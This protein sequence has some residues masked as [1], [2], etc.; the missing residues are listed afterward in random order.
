MTDGCSETANHDQALHSSNSVTDGDEMD[1]VAVT[2]VALIDV[3]VVTVGIDRSWKNRSARRKIHQEKSQECGG[4]Q[5]TLAQFDTEK[6]CAACHSQFDRLQK[7]E[8]MI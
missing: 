7:L 4:I 8:H 3:R 2:V 1:F 6:R 5:E